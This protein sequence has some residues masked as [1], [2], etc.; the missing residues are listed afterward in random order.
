MQISS[1]SNNTIKNNIV[2]SYIKHLSQYAKCV[3][4]VVYNLNFVEAHA[5]EM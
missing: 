3:P 2:Q 5:A 4:S 1:L